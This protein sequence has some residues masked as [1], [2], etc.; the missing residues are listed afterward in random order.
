MNKLSRGRLLI[1]IIILAFGV[2]TLLHG[3]GYMTIGFWELLGKYWPLLLIALGVDFLLERTGVGGKILGG[4]IFLLGFGFL[5]NNLEWFTLNVGGL[6]WP[7]FLILLGLS[8]L[9]GFRN[10]G[11]SNVAIMS[12]LE[13][14]DVWEVKSGS[15]FALMGGIEL[16]LRQ[17]Q[18]PEGTIHMNATA[19]VGGINIIVPPEVAVDCEGTAILGGVEFFRKNSGGIISTLHESQGDVKATKI[20]R[21]SCFTAMGGITVRSAAI[22]E[23]VDW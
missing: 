20:I 10:G 16:D 21:I 2:I 17:A 13:R 7:F 8:F 23:R 18:I 22:G 15:Y 3:F 11:Q 19:F 9:L 5:G 12:G 6:I 1:G 4:F 14:K